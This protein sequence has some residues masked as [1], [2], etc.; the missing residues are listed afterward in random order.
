MFVLSKRNKLPFIFRFMSH[1]YGSPHIF[2]QVLSPW[3]DNQWTVSDLH[4]ELIA[5][6]V[7]LTLHLSVITQPIHG[8]Q[9]SPIAQL[10]NTIAR[11]IKYGRFEIW[12]WGIEN[13]YRAVNL[14]CV[15]IYISDKVKFRP[16]SGHE[17]SDRQ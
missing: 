1:N 15:Y 12:L 8:Q 7:T 13:L 17:S 4:I 10:N 16:I 11:V 9:F 2:P 3:N 14:M 6:P 5:C